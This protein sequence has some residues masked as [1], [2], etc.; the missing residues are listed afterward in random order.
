MITQ[1]IY[2][3][4]FI[5]LSAT[6]CAGEHLDTEQNMR[7]RHEQIKETTQEANAAHL[8]KIRIEA[9]SPEQVK[10]IMARLETQPIRE[11]IEFVSDGHY[12]FERQY[13]RIIAV[14]EVKAVKE[15]KPKL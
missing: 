5:G 6:C 15:I 13:G 14:K 7:K 4:L 8:H 12:V 11:G 2:T 9:M 3:L 10:K 1:K